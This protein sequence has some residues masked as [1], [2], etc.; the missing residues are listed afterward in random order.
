MTAL[1]HAF[2]QLPQSAS[3]SGQSVFAWIKARLDARRRRV[4]ERIQIEHLRRLSPHHLADAGVDP[5]LL[6]SAVARIAAA[7]E[8]LVLAGRHSNDISDHPHSW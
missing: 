8:S 5:G 2:F 7:H 1:Q 4:M 6:Y 3:S